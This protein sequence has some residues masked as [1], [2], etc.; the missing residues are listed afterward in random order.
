MLIK[1]FWIYSVSVERTREYYSNIY[2]WSI[3]SVRLHVIILHICCSNISR[4]LFYCLHKIFS[5]FSS[6]ASSIDFNRPSETKT[7][8]LFILCSFTKIRKYTE[9]TKIG[10]LETNR[11]WGN[12]FPS[13]PSRIHL[14]SQF[15]PC[16]KF[17]NY[18]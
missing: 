18:L 11:I 3:C 5:G 10:R 2:P 7:K 14:W 16:A 6:L 17:Q 13:L 9:R 15:N 1:K 8:Y 4:Q 12:N